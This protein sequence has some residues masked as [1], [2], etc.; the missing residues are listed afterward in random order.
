MPCQIMS[1]MSSVLC[2]IKVSTVYYCCAFIKAHTNCRLVSLVAMQA[3][4]GLDT[5]EVQ[6]HIAGS[7]RRLQ[8]VQPALYLL[9]WSVQVTAQPILLNKTHERKSLKVEANVLRRTFV[10]RSKS[11]RERKFYGTKMELLLP[12]AK[13]LSRDVKR[14]SNIRLSI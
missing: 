2:F 9:V 1:I 7:V 10:L 8:I 14:L 3:T 6:R 13:V 12:G 4:H 11:S 5:L